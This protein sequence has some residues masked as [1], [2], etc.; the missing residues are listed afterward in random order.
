ME[1]GSFNELELLSQE[2]LI[3]DTL[4]K[5]L[6]AYAE[7]SR[8][9]EVTRDFLRSLCGFS[10]ETQT[11]FVLWEGGGAQRFTDLLRAV[12]CARAKLSEILRELLRA[13]LVRMVG[14][15]YQA[16]SPAWLVHYSE[17]NRRKL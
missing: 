13:E 5:L 6:R 2:D 9:E 10:L 15:R 16:I 12:G 11:W 7:L 8:R 17:P 14:K 4:R 3:V 1:E